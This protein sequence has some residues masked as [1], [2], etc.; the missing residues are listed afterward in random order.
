MPSDVAVLSYRPI[1]PSN[2]TVQCYRPIYIAVRYANPDSTSI[3]LRLCP[4]ALCSPE[5]E[6]TW[7][8]KVVHSG[9][10]FDSIESCE[11]SFELSWIVWTE[12]F[13]LFVLRSR[14]MAF[15]AFFSWNSILS[16]CGS[17]FAIHATSQQP[18]LKSQTEVWALIGRFLVV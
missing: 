6:Q 2:I 14:W 4:A 3:N 13:D 7:F 9:G 18:S 12:R 5:T 16:S 15:I 10:S 11:S 8:S 1:L 17:D